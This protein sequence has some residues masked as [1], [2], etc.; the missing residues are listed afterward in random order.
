[1]V[2]KQ[3]ISMVFDSLLRYAHLLNALH[4]EAYPEFPEVDF[5]GLP[6]PKCCRYIFYNIVSYPGLYR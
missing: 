2:Q 1:M 3:V 5:K 4:N 6:E